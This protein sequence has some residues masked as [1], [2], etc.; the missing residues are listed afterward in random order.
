MSSYLEEDNVCKHWPQNAT[1][2][3]SRAEMATDDDGDDDDNNDDDDN[4]D[5][6]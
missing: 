5:D 3:S 6:C 4:D 1:L 2:V